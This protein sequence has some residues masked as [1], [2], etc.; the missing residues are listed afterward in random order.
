MKNICFINGSPK[1]KNSS[2]FFYLNKLDKLM[3]EK[4]Y[5]KDYID[6]KFTEK[7]SLE[8][9]FKKIENADTIIIAFPLYVYCLPGILIRFFEDYY[10]YFKNKGKFNKNVRVYTIVNCGFPEPKINTEAIRIIE[11]FCNRLNLYWRFG[12]GIGMGE[13]ISTTKNIPFINKLSNNIFNTI[14]EVI[15]DIENESTDKINNFFVKP[16]MP[17]YL[18]FISANIKWIKC[19]KKNSLKKSDLFRL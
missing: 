15:K 4:E 19:A 7:N 18:F 6:V 8:D 2:S 12:I 9:D 1:G 5:I 10:I 13:F 11:N 16:K 14:H 3:D 17:K